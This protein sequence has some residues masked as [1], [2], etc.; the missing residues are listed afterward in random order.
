MKFILFLTC[1]V[2]FITSTS[3]VVAGGGRHGGAAVF[4]PAPVVVVHPEAEVIV[5]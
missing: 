4:V 3:C 5:R 1:I 2:T